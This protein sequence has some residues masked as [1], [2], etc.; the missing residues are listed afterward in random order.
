MAALPSL[1]FVEELRLRRWAIE[2]Y[3]PA[4]QRDDLHPVIVHE[5]ERMD[6]QE[7]RTAGHEMRDLVVTATITAEPEVPAIVE[8]ETVVEPS[9]A[10]GDE[11]PGMAD[12]AA[13]EPVRS[14]ALLEALTLVELDLTVPEPVSVE[15]ATVVAESAVDDV[16]PESAAISDIL[17]EV[18]VIQGEAVVAPIPAP[19]PAMVPEVKSPPQ[20]LTALPR[21]R[22]FTSNIVPILTDFEL[23]HGPHEFRPP[24]LRA[25]AVEA[26][27]TPPEMYYT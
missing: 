8:V 5:M 27:E 15:P 10:E 23:V 22:R 19:V 9:A 17:E 6:R 3:V 11:E 2:N 20:R 21:P 14:E 18:A 16:Q 24:H 12:E 7:V 25:P 4:D 13:A 26:T 1:D